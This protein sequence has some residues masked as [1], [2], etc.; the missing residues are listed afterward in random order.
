MQ[1]SV[2]NLQDGATIYNGDCEDFLYNYLN[3]DI[4]SEFLLN[5]FCCNQSQYIIIATDEADYLIEKEI[6]LIY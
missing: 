6:E 4:E 1:I 5:Q 2:T 3:S